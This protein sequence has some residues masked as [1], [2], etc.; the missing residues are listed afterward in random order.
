M[1]ST[2]KPRQ[3]LAERLQA[4]A[5]PSIESGQGMALLEHVLGVPCEAR[6]VS[7]R[8]TSLTLTCDGFVMCSAENRD[9]SPR[10]MGDFFGAADDCRHNLTGWARFAKL[11]KRDVADLNARILSA[12]YT[13][14][15]PGAEKHVPLVLL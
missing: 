12:F 14:A 11:G 10:F 4:G 8:I 6:R 7:P 3:T 15:S 2:R 13:G 5:L 1:T 9:G